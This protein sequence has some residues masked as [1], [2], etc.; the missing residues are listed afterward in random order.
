MLTYKQILNEITNG[1]IEICPFDLDRLNPNSYNL[2]LSPHMKIYK[3]DTLDMKDKESLNN[4]EDIIILED[5]YLLKPGELYIGSTIERTHT[6]KF[7][8]CISGRSS[9]GRLG[10]NV[11]VTAGFGDIGFDGKWTLE[12]FAIKPVIIYPEIEICQIYFFGPEN[13]TDKQD[14]E[15]ILYNGK[16]NGQ[17][18]PETSKIYKELR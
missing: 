15:N 3:S 4:Y 1:D 16:Y 13:I 12:I 5:G 18:D 6:D 2:R 9:I 11:H 7:I 8:P 14:S 10:I 17:S